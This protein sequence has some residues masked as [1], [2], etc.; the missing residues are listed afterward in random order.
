MKR[1]KK[2]YGDLILTPIEWIVF[3]MM[4]MMLIADL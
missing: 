2:N 3:G 4:L 1:P